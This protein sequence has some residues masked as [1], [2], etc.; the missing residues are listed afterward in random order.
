[1]LLYGVSIAGPKFHLI[2]EYVNGDNLTSILFDTDVGKYYNLKRDSIAHQVT[3]ALPYLHEVFCVH[4][5]I[6]LGDI[7]VTNT[8]N[9]AKLRDLGL[10]KMKL[11]LTKDPYDTSKGKVVRQVGAPAYMVPGEEFRQKVNVLSNTH[12]ERSL[13]IDIIVDVE[14]HKLKFRKVNQCNSITW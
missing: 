8:D 7:L 13:A 4:R 11:T 9:R 3:V 6:K 12:A 14:L 2:M 10:A 5:D 1:M